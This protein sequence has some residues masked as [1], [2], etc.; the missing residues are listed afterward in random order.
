MKK[1]IKG[2]DWYL[3][4]PYLLLCGIGIVM[5][6]SASAGIGL[7]HGGF[8]PD[9]LV[10]QAAF[11]GI[12]LLLLVLVY[13]MRFAV[14]QKPF[15]LGI[16]EITLL[17]LL[18]YVKF[19]GTKVNG[20]A[21]WLSLGFIKL[22]PAE[23]CK[24][25]FIIYFANM[26][27][28]RSRLITQEGILRATF[29]NFTPLIVPALCL[30]LILFQPDTGGFAINLFIIL[31]MF[32]AASTASKLVP[33]I[34]GLVL[35]LPLFL[36]HIGSGVIAHFVSNSQNYK[37]QRFVSFADPFLHAQTSGQQLINSYYAI[38]NGGI[39][40]RGLGNSIQKMG[41]LAEPNTDFI[42]P[43]ISEELGLVGV[44]LILALLC[45]LI[46]R[47]IDIGFRT[48][49]LYFSSV[50]YGTAAYLTIQT[51]FNAGGAVGFV[52]LTGVTLP[53]ISYGGSSMITLSLCL[54]LVMKISSKERQLSSQRQPGIQ[55]PRQ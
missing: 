1:F 48:T 8:A 22:Q 41:Y 10:K 51:L 3:F 30:L 28:K 47:T 53:F 54:G 24:F 42:L 27:N 14:F 40:G 35:I 31:V 6:Y 44:V 21:G 23:L 17:V 29:H 52:P 5:V 55:I 46:V 26:F 16:L 32:L 11:V 7:T 38:S 18:V 19:F 2:L 9:Y 49:N 20:A 37:L 36:I 50:C 4:F 12:S 43:I 33:W 34:V 13:R 25:Y 39:F 15:F 45:I